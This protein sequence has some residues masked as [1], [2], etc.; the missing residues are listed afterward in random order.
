MLLPNYALGR[1][2]MDISLSYQSRQRC[3]DMPCRE[4]HCEVMNAHNM[5]DPCC[6]GWSAGAL[7][8]TGLTSD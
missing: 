5:T 8:I 3:E 4:R 7:S 6:I 1:G 2:L